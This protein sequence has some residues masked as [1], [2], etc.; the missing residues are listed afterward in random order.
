MKSVGL[1]G[2]KNPFN[3][4]NSNVFFG[5]EREYLPVF[6]RQYTNCLLFLNRF[7]IDL[8]VSFNF[9]SVRFSN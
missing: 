1:N 7:S 9:G 3:Y 6:F 2:Y 8:P 5:I 4:F